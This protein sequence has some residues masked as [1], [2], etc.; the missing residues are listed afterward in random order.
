MTHEIS[1]SELKGIW[2]RRKKVILISFALL[3]CTSLLVALVLPS[4]YESRVMIIVENQ[5]IPEQY[6]KST[7]TSY[8]SERLE[9][10]ERKILSY[11]R[12]LKIINTNNLYPELSSNGE[13]VGQFREDITLETIDVTLNDS[14]FGRGLAT[15]AFTLSYQSK[16][17][18][19][20]KQITDILAQLFV[21]EDRRER[22]KRAGTTTGFLEKEMEDLR[23]QVKQNEE[24][25]SRFKAANI[26][27]LPGST[28]IFQQT[29]F[30]LEEDIDNT[31]N[32][33][34][35]LQEKIVYLKSQ[36]ANIDPMVPILTESGKVANN[37][38]NRLKYLRLQL[39]QMQSNL[40]EK[41]PD[42]IRLKSEIAELE[43]QTNEK[44]TSMEKVN[45]LII[46][47]KTAC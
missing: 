29:V 32:R 4:I 42:I 15:I 23:S 9:L 34:R 8:I 35:T 16:D 40:S 14:R 21:E 24:K 19:K 20:A 17:P 27:Q 33:I 2:R 3:F 10:L 37:P 1:L 43:A 5:E 39:I 11:P 30:R 36:L 47:K 12:L 25:I 26:N 18:E 41:H 46:V 6:V 44:D 7:T 28:A 22:E 38:N 31:V 45:R 13:M